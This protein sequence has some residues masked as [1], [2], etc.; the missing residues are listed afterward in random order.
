MVSWRSA[1]SDFGTKN[2]PSA[3][4]PKGWNNRANVIRRGCLGAFALG[5]A[6]LAVHRPIPA[7]LKGDFAF[8]LAVRADGFVHLTRPAIPTTTAEST[9]TTTERHGASLWLLCLYGN[10]RL[11]GWQA[12]FQQEGALV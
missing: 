6:L 5:K 2:N 7:G 12:F 11:P 1:T 8:L 4:Q 10:T 9:A 3:G